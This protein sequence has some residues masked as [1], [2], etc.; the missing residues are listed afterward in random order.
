MKNRGSTTRPL[1]R[2][3]ARNL[4]ASGKYPVIPYKTKFTLDVVYGQA[5]YSNLWGLQGTTAFDFS[6]ILGNHRISFG[7]EM[8]IDLENSD[9]YLSYMYLAKR[10]NW[11]LTGFHTANIWYYS[12]LELYRLRNYGVDFS[13]IAAVKPLFPD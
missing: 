7:T 3:P 6:D 12:Y 11:A 1:S 5:G 9:Y 13:V 10:T 4:S 2:I 8:Y